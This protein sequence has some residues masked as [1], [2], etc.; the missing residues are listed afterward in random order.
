[1][2]IDPRIHKS[3]S[4]QNLCSKICFQFS[5][6]VGAP[7]FSADNDYWLFLGIYPSQSHVVA[8]SCLSNEAVN[9]HEYMRSN[10]L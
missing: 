2:L 8:H 3:F 4:S 9:E 1:M 5:H 10:C 6:S 7:N